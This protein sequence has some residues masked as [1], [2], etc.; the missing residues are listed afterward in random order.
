MHPITG[1]D[2]GAFFNGVADIPIRPLALTAVPAQINFQETGGNATVTLSLPKNGEN[3]TPVIFQIRKNNVFDWFTVTPASGVITPGETLKLTV[4]TDPAKIAGRPDFRGAFLVRTPNGLSRPVTVYAKGNYTEDKRPASA[5]N[6]IYLKAESG[7][8]NTPINIKK[9]GDYSVLARV[10]PSPARGGQK[11]DVV[12]NG[13]N[14]PAAGQSGYWYLRNGVERVLYL[15]KLGQ[16]KAGTNQIDIKCS[17]PTLT[18]VE[19]IITDHPQVFF[20]QNNFVKK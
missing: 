2:I 3:D 10:I 1:D 19:Y 11:F 4:T 18:I 6:T 13:N 17:N 16:L 12:I 5:P 15:S 7:N 14:S 8:T 20:N 9:D